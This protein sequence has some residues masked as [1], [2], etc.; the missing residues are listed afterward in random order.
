MAEV[1]AKTP[2]KAKEDRKEDCKEQEP[3][4]TDSTA[5]VSAGAEKKAFLVTEKFLT[6]ALGVGVL[7]AFLRGEHLKASH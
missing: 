1:A 2:E 6:D 3:T 7:S 5:S 4:K